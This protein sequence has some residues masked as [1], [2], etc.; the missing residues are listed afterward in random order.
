MNNLLEDVKKRAQNWLSEEFDAET[1]KEVAYLLE[2]NEK[3]LIDSFYKDL[4]F[5][6]GGL[7]GIMGAGTNRMNI[8]TVAKATQGLANYVKKNF[9]NEELKAVIAHDCRNNGRKFAETTADVLASNGFK[10]FLFDDLR[11]TPELSFAIR[12]L[13]CQTGIVITASHNP[14]EYN[15]YKAYWNDGAQLIS[16]HDK[17][18][19]E[20][21]RKITRISEVSR[22]LKAENISIIGK[23]IDEKYLDKISSLINAKEEIKQQSKLKIVYTP[24]HGTGVRLVPEILKKIGFENIYTVEEQMVNDGNFPT[25]ESPNPEN[26]EALSMAITKAKEV[27]AEIVMATDPDAD[28][29]G[30]AVKINDEF[31]LL[32]GNQTGSILAYYLLNIW[33]EKNKLTGNEYI[34]KTIVTT[35]LIAEIAKSFNVEYYDVL[36]GFKYI[37]GIMRENEGKKTFVFGGEESYGYLAGDFIRDKDAVMACA[38]IAETAAWAKANRKTLWDILMEIYEKY[39]YYQEALINV[40]KKG[41]EGAEEILNMMEN[42]RQNPPTKLGGAKVS[43][44][45]DYQSSQSRNIETEEKN[46]I[47]LPKSNVLQFITTDGTKISVR[48][49]GTEPKIKF[50][51]SVR[52]DAD[53]NFEEKQKLA[54]EKIAK[55][56]QDLNLN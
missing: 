19:I 35:E 9:P 14:K 6:T 33:K 27:G 15:G 24:I 26:S 37:A 25:V 29:V 23:E 50:Y 21:V 34:V 3:E 7:R 17:N 18:V 13:G 2:N 43:I 49:S 16:P 56:K 31:R 30:I 53:V 51:I 20:E 10:V 47:D 38:L 48:P 32:N 41:K 55:I 52:I 44:I 46:V 45:K 42:Y 40:V 39:G 12:E 1:R 22:G 4:E 5:G 28:R 8:Y 11:P 54:F 36:T